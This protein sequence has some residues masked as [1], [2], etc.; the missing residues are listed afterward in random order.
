MTLLPPPQVLTLPRV[1]RRLLLVSLLMTKSNST[2]KCAGRA[3]P[4]VVPAL[5]RLPA[6]LSAAVCLCGQ[7]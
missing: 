7:L 5:L 6:D 2:E 4:A 1:P 3:V